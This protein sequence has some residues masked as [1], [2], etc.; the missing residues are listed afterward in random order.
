MNPNWY[1][2]DDRSNREFV[3]AIIQPINLRSVDLNL[4]V[5]LD[6]LLDEAHVSR[7]A[8]RLNLS[9][10]A[11][12]AA[13]Q[14]CRALF[15]DDL[16]ERGR[17]TMW[18]TPKAEALRA[19]LKSLLAGAL[20]LIDPPAVPVSEISRVLHLS[21]ADYP[22]V[23]IVSPLQRALRKVASG[24]DLVIQPW[25]SAP[26]AV[27]A[28]RHGDTDIAIS[29]L[30][31]EEEDLFRTEL[32][33]ET[34]VVALRADHPAVQTF[35]LDRWLAWPHIVVSGSGARRGNLDAILEAA[36]RQRRIG[37]V[38]PSFQMV[39]A[40]L[41]DSDMI[42]LMPRHGPPQSALAGLR[43]LHPP[44]HVP[45]FALH[46]AWHRRNPANPVIDLVTRLLT[47]TVQGI[48]AVEP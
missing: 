7:A 48:S 42:A 3:Y 40:L 23:A 26:D 24:I 29:V 22:A 12:S 6:A 17:G 37:L 38:V 46:M 9:Q 32:L 16:L 45:G 35:D 44:L 47:E 18:R 43:I 4:L 27:A 11:T 8:Q 5:V 36:G 30:D 20:D 33:Y 15:G 41:A 14:R 1:T 31:R 34:Y 19:P 39:P 2:S 28:L 13:L 21:M 10:P 25:H